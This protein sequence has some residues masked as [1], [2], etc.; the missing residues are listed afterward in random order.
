MKTAVF[1]ER[2]GVLN[3]VKSSPRG[4]ITPLAYEEFKIKADAKAPLE[5]LKAA[6]FVLLATTNQPGLSRG[7]QSRRDLDRMHE[8]LRRQLPIEDVMVCPHDETD[9]CPCRAPRPGLLIEL[10]FKWH[11]NLERSFV[12]SD[13]WQDAAAARAAGCVSILLKSPWLGQ[14]NCD[15]VLNTLDEIADKIIAINA[16][17][18]VWPVRVP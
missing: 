9:S 3:E 6:G 8:L 7:Y 12:V 5:K 18:P 2:D 13:R 17:R 1:F 14:V 4:K 16:A 15:F 11:L 10:A